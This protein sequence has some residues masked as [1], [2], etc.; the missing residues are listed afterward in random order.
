MW[1][2]VVM[3]A[4][5]VVCMVAAPLLANSKSPRFSHYTV[6]TGHAPTQT[7]LHFSRPLD[8]RKPES[9]RDYFKIT[10][11]VKPAL[12]VDGPRLCLSGLAFA[13]P[14]RITLLKGLPDGEGGRSVD[15]T[16]VTVDLGDRQPRIGFTGNGAFILPRRVVGTI[17]L[18][19]INVEQ[20]WI[21][22]HR[23]GDRM[24]APDLRDPVRLTRS[25]IPPDQLHKLLR[26]HMTPIWSGTIQT[27]KEHN[28]KV[29]TTFA[30]A[31]VVKNRQPGVYLVTAQDAR[32][33]KRLTLHES[34]DNTA[35]D[36][37]ED[38]FDWE[39]YDNIAVQWVVD[40]DLGVSALQGRDG[41][42]LFVRSLANGTPVSGATVTLMA[43]NNEELARLTTDAHGG[44]RFDPGLLRGGGGLA[45]A[46]VLAYGHQG[47]FTVMDL[48]RPAFDL[49]D[50]GVGGR[51][52]PG[53]LDG[54]LYT[55][56]GIYRPGETVHLA[57]LLRDAAVISRAGQPL[58][59]VIRRPNGSEFQQKRAEP[60]GDGAYLLDVTLPTTAARGLW[61][62]VA[63]L[64]GASQPVGQV[65]FDVQDFVPQRLKVLASMH[66]QRL[67]P[68]DPVVVDVDA[69]FLYGAPASG[70]RGEGELAVKSDPVP[71]AD[72]KEYGFGK[73]V[74]DPAPIRLMVPDTD[75]KG[76]TTATG[77]LPDGP[78]GNPR[79]AEITVRVV[80]P[81]G[82]ATTTVVEKPILA[83]QP[84]VGI[85]PLFREDRVSEGEEA[86]FHVLLVAPDGTA[87]E[88]PELHYRLLEE[89]TDHQWY[90]QNQTWKMQVM[91]RDHLVQE[92]VVPVGAGQPGQIA[93][94]G[95]GWGRFRLEVRDPG[96]GS[97]SLRRFQVGWGGHDNTDVPDKA[98]VRS[99]KPFYQPGE[100]ARIQI[101]TPAPGPLQVV[102]ATDRVWESRSLQVEGNKGVTVEIP[103]K[104]E[105]GAGA[106]VLVTSFRPLG[107][108]KA[109]DPVRAVG[110]TWLGIDPG[111]H[112]LQVAM[113]L[114]EK[115][116]P[117]RLTI[118]VAVQGADSE[119]I[120]L[121]LA[122]VDEG[123][124]QLT[125]FKSPDPL[126]HYM[127]KRRL[128]VEVR[129][130]YG[131]LLDGGQGVAGEIRSGGDGP[132]G[133]LPVVPTKSTALF[134]GLVALDERG[135]A[136]VH[137][138]VPSFNGK[139]RLMAVAHSR[140]RVGAAEGLVTV[141][142]PV[143]GEVSLPRFLAPDD[144]GRLTLLVQNM[145]LP[146]GEVRVRLTA[147]GAL[148]LPDGYY[149]SV[150]MAPEDRLIE[151]VPVV[152]GSQAG[153]GTVTLS[154]SAGD[155]TEEREW[156]IA[157]RAP[158]RP[159]T[160]EET[161]VQ[162]PDESWTLPAARW[163]DRQAE[164]LRVQ[165]HYGVRKELD[166]AGLLNSLDRYPFGCTEQLTS[167]AMALLHFG[168]VMPK[169]GED[170]ATMRDRA[171]IQG[172]VNQILER[173]DAEGGVG[174]YR[175]GDG[176]L[177]H[178]LAAFVMDLL[179]QAADQGFFV[180]E[181]ALESGYRWLRE[182]SSHYQQ[183][184]YEKRRHSTY[185][186]YVLARRGKVDLGELRY[187]HDNRLGELP[188]QDRAFLGA[189]LY[190][191]GDVARAVHALEQA[192]AVMESA[193][194]APYPYFQSRLQEWA[195]I[196]ALA[197]ESKQEKQVAAAL[198]GISQQIE[199]AERLNTQEK[200]WL[201]RAAALLA[202]SEPLRVAHNGQ[203]DGRVGR[204]VLSWVIDAP[205]ARVE[206]FVNRTQ[207]D[208]WRTLTITGVPL[209]ALP[210]ESHEVTI[211]R[212]LFSLSGQPLDPGQLRQN[213]RFI[214][215]LTGKLLK[216]MHRHLVLSDLLPAGWEIEGVIKG[217]DE[218]ESVYPFLPRMTELAMREARDDRLVAAFDVHPAQTNKPGS[219][220]AKEGTAQKSGSHPLE[221]N[222][223]HV[224]YVVRAVTPGRFVLPPPLVEDM[225]RSTVFARGATGQTVVHV[226]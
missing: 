103:V 2:H 8:A 139:L 168:E 58:Q 17:G 108:G 41:L 119:K 206:Q 127:G 113:E 84:L 20:A 215:S 125:R 199:P 45:P 128:A 186:L 63:H 118:P 207:R 114:P 175:A 135:Q 144:Q 40:T 34:P 36:D 39:M 93:A 156:S 126:G 122:A 53:E 205:G 210:A 173:Q 163:A 49:S 19:S 204:G 9:Y 151:T 91:R 150:T 193:Q 123:I 226:P 69:V 117:G 216:P 10:P 120:F 81:G 42:H 212:T 202:G 100:T 172:V 218:G 152:A 165:L 79:K 222:A 52:H 209:R 224:A 32:R 154:L 88:R 44:V 121:T 48:K 68:A 85:R 160:T 192:V 67:S 201:L 101:Q 64:P 220:P 26:R 72:F 132:G 55:D 102:V 109:R 51:S 80:E 3:L 75:A 149:K 167:R 177:D 46:A 161:A 174:L 31:D 6:D 11:E 141:R 179:Q 59:F 188:G 92:G 106:Y 166:P 129:D 214:V 197:L 95:L 183:S 159:V 78:A 22:I 124:L 74:T 16:Q 133:A 225:Y 147:A 155:Y 5:V 30:F 137:L 57:A 195:A 219:P 27:R 203:E 97:E 7:C 77:L 23:L 131:R 142:H 148:S 200:A 90:F 107:R 14:Y 158:H 181:V 191:L 213:D 184:R 208:L 169:K 164:G 189:A 182:L 86:R 162:K 94:Q 37:G 83:S 196:L 223:F 211:L 138:D 15:E 76:H 33:P 21:T 24:V 143:V 171:V 47:D 62:V 38:R 115:I 29:H 61:Q 157:V 60:A 54:Y 110:L 217:N 104:K 98:E 194:N 18:E 112:A 190:R 71:F 25:Q 35:G 111:Q 170:P 185:L 43:V 187:L 198:K 70:L 130:D 65:A 221:P 153:I 180:P 89:Q 50:R 96:G 176:W 134:S 145:D 73:P 28:Q 4:G 13:T 116:Q 87:L 136:T 12:R 140:S 66:E 146:S 178:Y 105:W 99:D 56:R 82:R 1:R